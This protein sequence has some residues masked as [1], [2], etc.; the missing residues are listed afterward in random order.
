MKGMKFGVAICHEGWRYPE[1]VRWAA[2][3]GAAIVFHPHHTGSDQ[4][5]LPLTQWG[6]AGNPYYEKAMLM[7]SIENTV[8]FAS[9]NYALRFQ[10]S[11]TSLITPS[12]ECQAYLPYG[13]EG[14]LVQA[15]SLET[16]TGA[17]A[18]RYAPERYQEFRAA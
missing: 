13:Q 17:L 5:G 11:A 9:V 1:T 12:G 6:A 7:R 10:E 8:Y 15:V 2:V 18:A 14:V 4:T 16:A 3:R